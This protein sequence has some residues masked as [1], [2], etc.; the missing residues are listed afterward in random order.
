MGDKSRYKH[1]YV[2]LYGHPFNPEN[3]Q[4]VHTKPWCSNGRNL[5]AIYADGYEDQPFEFSN[6]LKTQIANALALGTSQPSD[7]NS[8]VVLL[9]N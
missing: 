2:Y 9:K 1:W 7:A 4:L 3:Y 8:P 5:C 6:K